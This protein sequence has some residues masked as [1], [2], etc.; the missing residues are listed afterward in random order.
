MRHIVPRKLMQT[1]YGGTAAVAETEDMAD[2]LFS[3]IYLLE[4]EKKVRFVGC[5][6]EGLTCVVIQ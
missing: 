4:T 2:F 6:R 5:R 3:G 1:I